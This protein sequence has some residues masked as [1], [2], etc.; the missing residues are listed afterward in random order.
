MD[1]PPAIHWPRLS[2][3]GRSRWLARLNRLH[4]KVAA[5]CDRPLLVLKTVEARADIVRERRFG[6]VFG[7][8]ELDVDW[9]YHRAQMH[10]QT[11]R[12]QRSVAAYVLG[13][14]TLRAAGIDLPDAVLGRALRRLDLPIEP[15][16]AFAQSL[17]PLD[18]LRVPSDPRVRAAGLMLG[19]A[20]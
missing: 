6:E 7:W 15:A 9:L 11:F 17:G 2:A 20:S 4:P 19:Y 16:A 1:T 5:A 12:Q 3:G 10:G 13:T 18:P 8:L 14:L